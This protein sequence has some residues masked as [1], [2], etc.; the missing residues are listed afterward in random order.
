MHV[1][2][3]Y[4][5]TPRK[6]AVIAPPQSFRK[7]FSDKFISKFYYIQYL[8]MHSVFQNY[9]F[10]YFYMIFQVSIFDDVLQYK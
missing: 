10:I 8:K 1:T 5:S 4:P 6:K 2:F 3:T 7:L 9:H